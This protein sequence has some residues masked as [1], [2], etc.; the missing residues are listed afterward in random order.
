MRV[1]ER[2]WKS[3]GFAHGFIIVAA[4]WILVALATLASIYSM[5]ITICRRFPDG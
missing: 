1:H 2:R 4:W 5:T 3:F